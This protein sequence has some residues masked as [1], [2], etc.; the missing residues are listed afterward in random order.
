MV[1]YLLLIL[2]FVLG[3]SAVMTA[4]TSLSGKVTDLETGEPILFGNVKIYQNQVYKTGVQTDFDGNFSFSPLDGGTYDVEVSYVGYPPKRVEGVV[5]KAGKDNRLD[6]TLEAGINLDEVVVIGYEVPLIDPD[7]TATGGTVTGDQIMR[8]PS[9]SVNGIVSNVAGTASADEGDDVTIKGSRANATVY[10]YDGIRV[11]GNLPPATEIEQLQV[12]TGGVG[13]QYGDVTGGIISI[14]SRGP[15]NRFS[16][17]IEVETSEFLDAFGYNLLNANVSGPILR[18]KEGQSVLGFRIAGQYRQRKDD[19]P[20]AIPIYHVSDET[21]ASL[22]ANPIVEFGSGF[23]PAGSFVDFSGMDEYAYRPNEEDVNIDFTAKLDAQLSRNIDVSFSGTY[24]QNKDRFTPDG[25]SDNA[26]RISWTQFNSQNNPYETRTRYRGNVRL[27]HRLG[28]TDLDASTDNQEVSAI[29]NASYTL[30]FGY[31]QYYYNVEDTRHEDRFFDYGYIGQYDYEWVPALGAPIDAANWPFPF[32]HR[33][34]RQEFVGYTGGDINPILANYNVGDD[35]SSESQLVAENG[36]I[37]T[38]FSRIW[39]LHANVG[40]VYNLYRKRDEETITFNANSSFE[41][42]PSN[43]EDSKHSIQ[44]GVLYEQRTE[45]GYDLQPFSLWRIAEQQA[46]RNILGV[47]TTKII[48]DTLVFGNLI[49]IYDV[50]TAEQE[51]LLFYKRVREVAGAADGD[52]V[53]VHAL[54]PDQMSLDMFSSAE[55]T[56]QNIL[57]YWGYDYLG[58]PIEGTYDAFF[59][60]TDANGVRTFPVAPFRPNYLAAYIQDRFTFRDIIFRVGV[61]VDRYD[62]NTN[63]LK[64]PFSLYEIM[65]ASDFHDQFGGERPSTIGDDFK[66]YIDGENSENV[67]AYRDGEQWYFANGTEANDGNLIFGGEVVTPKYT[68]DDPNIQKR[69]FDPSLTFEDYTPQI[70]VMPRMAFS[71]PISDEANFF[72]HY[73]VLVQ[74]PP[75]NNVATPIDYYYFAERTEIRNNP[76]LRPERTI[77]YEVGFQQRLTNSSALKISAYYKELRDMIQF[78]TFLYVPGINGQQYDTYDNLDF[79]TVK[80]FT[81]QYDLRRTGNVSLLASYTLQFADGTG[82]DANSSRGLSST[83]LQR[84]LYP[85]SFDERHR[86]NMSLDYRYGSGKKYNGPRLFGVDIFANGGLNLQA[87]A[88]SGRPYTAKLVPDPLGGASTKGSINGSRLPWNF[89][90]NLRVDKDFTLVKPKAENGRGLNMNVYVRVSNVLDTRNTVKVYPATGSPSDDGYLDS[91]RGLDATESITNSGNS[92][93]AFLAS[94]Q[95]RM[96]NPTYYTLPRR[97]FLGAI[98]DF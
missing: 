5:V 7:N 74:R 39:N 85:L 66:V 19:D 78:R 87:I 58:N 75:S 84:I 50:V 28:A 72:A 97:I 52:Y 51:D 1:R 76:N 57:D 31:E 91:S 70:N 17:G 27:R 62:A 25:Y 26:S 81:F 93:D 82:S 43:S 63:V 65:G 34:Y 2:T 95:W 55:L 8:L 60:E 88:V 42:W 73:D 4:Q 67:K 79:G 89:V 64:D 33:D 54:T 40:T 10:F 6:I 96:L 48:G 98:F 46:N 12:I 69:G 15:S 80:G 41:L 35:I 56:G 13:A 9:K 21:L 22:E 20:T 16:G 47:D 59:T 92:P 38:N 68:V 83:G 29:R 37:S 61:R 77:D 18:N 49:P 53:N 44:F 23:V 90:L 14:T 30:Q 71:F 86:I 32:Q 24:N 45:R 11:S 36:F 3:G 94:Y